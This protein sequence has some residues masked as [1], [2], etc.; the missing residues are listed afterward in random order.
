M[1]LNEII[2]K[3]NEKKLT[4]VSFISFGLFLFFFVPSLV[5]I[6]FISKD[7]SEDPL[8]EG[9]N[10]Y[11]ASY[12]NSGNNIN[13]YVDTGNLKDV[14]TFDC[15]KIYELIKV[16]NQSLGEIFTLNI[17]KINSLSK[18]LIEVKLITLSFVIFDFMIYLII[19]NEK[20]SGFAN[21]KPKQ[22]NDSG[23]CCVNLCCLFFGWM[24][25]CFCSFFIIIFFAIFLILEIILF[26][27]ICAKY[28]NDETTKFLNF[29]KCNGINQDIIT[30]FSSL[31]DLSI[32]FNLIIILNSVYIVFFV[33]FGIILW[34]LIRLGFQ[35]PSEKM[36]IKEIKNKTESN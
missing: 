13:A 16:K 24:M 31:N 3:F 19:L 10:F 28:D 36:M 2:E 29:L 1:K 17:G 11:N 32:H 35:L 18:S 23:N 21:V 8:K 33:I 20:K 15:I 30:K 14:Y 7:T 25:S 9:I 22:K 6:F 26:S 5:F 27:I 12:F 4:T 34:H